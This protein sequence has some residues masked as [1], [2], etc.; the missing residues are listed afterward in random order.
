MESA[1]TARP[2]RGHKV[3]CL[4]YC[5]PLRLD[6]LAGILNPRPWNGLW[7]FPLAAAKRPQQRIQL[8]NP[9]SRQTLIDSPR[10]TR[11]KRPSNRRTGGS[12]GDQHKHVTPRKQLPGVTQADAGANTLDLN[13]GPVV[14]DYSPEPDDS[15]GSSS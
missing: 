2:E 14:G 4:L 9:G 15:P 5:H 6:D 11:I 13:L 10:H 7:L 3:V 1:Q 12:A 8:I